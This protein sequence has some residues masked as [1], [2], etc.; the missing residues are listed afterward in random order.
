VLASNDCYGGVRMEW[1]E[2]DTADDFGAI[3]DTFLNR[4]AMK[5]AVKDGD[6]TVSG[7]QNLRA[8]CMITHFGVSVRRITAGKRVGRRIGSPGLSRAPSAP[9]TLRRFS[10]QP[11]RFASR[12]RLPFPSRSAEPGDQ[13]HNASR[14]APGKRRCGRSAAS[15]AW[16]LLQRGDDGPQQCRVEGRA[17]TE[18]R[19][20]MGRSPQNETIPIHTV[21][22]YGA[23]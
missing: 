10:Q 6:I 8:T 13:S 14:L 21:S 18:S 12:C 16:L 23:R 22:L 15:S 17:A 20:T 2:R 4:A 3:R 19:A 7:S 9:G 5:F 1:T 11:C